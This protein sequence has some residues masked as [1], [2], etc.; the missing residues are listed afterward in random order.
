MRL[1]KFLSET[2]NGTRSE[3]KKLISSGGVSVNGKICRDPSAKISEETDDVRIGAAPVRYARYEY[4]M[5]NKPQGVISATRDGGNGKEVCATDLIRDKIRKD[6][7]PAGRLDKDTE[8][9]LLITND[10]GLAHRLLSPKKHVDKTYY[11]E[12]DAG[13]EPDAAERLMAGVDIGD[14][15]PT[16]PCGIRMLT[17]S[18]C[19][20]T[21]REGRYH[22]IKRMF[23]T[24]GRTVTY[25][26]RLTMGPLKLDEKLEPG[27]YRRLTPE[28]IKTIESFDSDKK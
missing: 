22:Q 2:G 6:L 11:V 5:L 3:V 9:L 19:L 8:G 16:L 14:E 18:S 1:D 4:F 7:F 12:L 17:D 10:G 24:E 13:M 25:L 27:D 23:Q 28:E 26:K 15:K 21:I 20:I